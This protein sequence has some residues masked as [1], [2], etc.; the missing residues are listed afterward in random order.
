M[1]KLL[2]LLLFP[3]FVLG[4]E[5]VRRSANHYYGNGDPSGNS[6]T[7]FPSL[8]LNCTY[9]NQVT[10]KVFKY[11]NTGTT[12]WVQ[13]NTLYPAGGTGTQG[14]IGPAGPQGP[15][16]DQGIQGQS[17]PV[18]PMGP[19]GPQ[20]PSGSGSGGSFPFIVVVG[21]GGDDRAVIQA[22]FN[23]NAID[24]R[25]VYFVGK[26]Y[27]SGEMTISKS[28]WRLTIMAYGATVRSLNSNTYTWF[29]RATPVDQSEALNLQINAKFFIYGGD[30]FGL[31]NQSLYDLGPSTDSRYQDISAENFNEVVRLRFSLNTTLENVS[32][33]GCVNPF[34]AGTGNWPGA[35]NANSQSNHTSFNHCNCYM[36]MNGNIA[37][38]IFAASG[39][40]V[41][42]SIIEGFS[43]NYGIFFDSNKSNV[44][45]DA[46]I[47]NVHFECA[48]GAYG[49]FIKMNY[50]AGCI[51][52]NKCYG[53]YPALFLDMIT[54]T[55]FTTCEISN[56]PWFVPST[57]PSA[58]KFVKRTGDVELYLER[59]MVSGP[60]K[61]IGSNVMSYVDNSGTTYRTPYYFE[62]P[63]G[64]IKINNVR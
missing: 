35:D 50:A 29:K 53:Q 27:H 23:Q 1:K 38:L 34:I 45:R 18:G 55:E 17:G 62:D 44:V 4:H 42:N 7:R 12:K 31:G 59:I 57:G 15:K 37:F 52:I 40:S 54:S 13:D 10:G 14:P 24:N 41:T 30:F 8:S 33:T 9:I 32:A 49:A 63:T 48:A 43:V 3:L 26:I 61:I 46:T 60:T 58:G 25:P 6:V 28:C 39:T 47:E 16:G 19:M 22:A 64:K 2:L 20:G 11:T 56:V 36:P 21:S 5:N 51:T